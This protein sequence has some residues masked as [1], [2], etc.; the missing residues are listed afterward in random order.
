MLC[1]E[2]CRGVW[3]QDLFPQEQDLADQELPLSDRIDTSRQ[4]LCRTGWQLLGRS[5]H[6]SITLERN[7]SASNRLNGRV[8]VSKPLLRSQNKR[9]RLI[10]AKKYKLYTVDNWKKVLFTDE[11]KVQFYGNSRRLYIRRR[12]GNV[13]VIMVLVICTEL[14]ISL[15]RKSTKCS[16][17]QKHAIPSGLKL[18]GHGFVL[19]QDNDPKHT[20]KLSR[21][22]LQGKE[23]H[24]LVCWLLWIFL[25]NPLISIQ[26]NIYGNI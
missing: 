17:L 25:L 14:T 5:K 4:P 10:W 12:F 6:C 24:G 19:Q 21:K 16:F 26:S 8:A 22:Y 20:S 1:S 13:L 11:Y 23:D 3:K 9:E 18:C 15:P 2:P 7:H